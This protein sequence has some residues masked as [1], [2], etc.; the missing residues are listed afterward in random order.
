MRV[1]DD[2]MLG[3]RYVELPED[4]R[5]RAGEKEQP[6]IATAFP[7]EYVGIALQVCRIGDN[8]WYRQQFAKLLHEFRGSAPLSRLPDKEET[9]QGREVS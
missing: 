6:G 4:H 9:Q 1:E 2:R 3:T 5:R 7:R 8:V